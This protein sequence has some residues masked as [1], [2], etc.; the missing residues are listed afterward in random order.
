MA[1]DDLIVANGGGA[2][3]RAKINAGLAALGSSMKGPN[4]PSAP[5]AGMMWLED[6]SPSASVWTL[7]MY[8]GADWAAVGRLDTSANVFAA[9][10]FPA[11]TAMLFMQ[12]AAPLGWTKSTT[13]DNK[14]LRIV[15]GTAGSGGSLGF[16]AAFASRSIT[17]TAQDTTLTSGQMANHVHTN[18]PT[19]GNVVYANQGAL[20]GYP[21]YTPGGNYIGYGPIQ[22]TGAV[23][24]NEGHGHSLAMNA[25]D[26]AVAYVDAIIATKD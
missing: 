26:M 18:S 3:V 10:A 22:S 5:V 24:N 23:G 9:N 25:L 21:D 7:R 11:G 14:A 20:F 6:D 13:H 8:D 15:S 17:G 2:A 19:G 1:Q 4:A 12:T 16:T